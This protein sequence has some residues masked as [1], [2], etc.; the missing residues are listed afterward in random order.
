VPHAGGAYSGAAKRGSNSL[1]LAALAAALAA[2]TADERAKLT[3][4]LDGEA[5]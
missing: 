5:E 3:Q 4:L 1:S 2:L